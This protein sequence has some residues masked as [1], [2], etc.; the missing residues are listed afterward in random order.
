MP[1]SMKD[2]FTRSHEH[3]FLLSKSA[4]YYFD[5][6]AVKEPGQ[7]WGHRKR[8]NS[9]WVENEVNMGS[10][11]TILKKANDCDYSSGRNRRSVWTISPK[12]FPGSHFAT[13]PP[14]IP[15]ICI[16]AGCPERGVVIDP[17]NG[18][19]TTGMVAHELGMKY[20]GIDIN[21]EYLDM[22][23]DRAEPILNQLRF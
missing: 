23:I 20:I 1:E 15:Q 12:P 16:K 19:G 21:K 6:E 18:S 10:Q 2:R 13:F 17:F 4:K 22:T 3:I 5:N 9:S 8:E 7:D 14:E 11:Q